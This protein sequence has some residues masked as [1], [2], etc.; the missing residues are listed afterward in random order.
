MILKEAEAITPGDLIKRTHGHRSGQ[1]ALVIAGG[2]DRYQVI[3]RNWVRVQYLSL[4][5]YEWVKKEA[6]EIISRDQ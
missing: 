5:D 3:L 2:A 6:V 1:I 4:G